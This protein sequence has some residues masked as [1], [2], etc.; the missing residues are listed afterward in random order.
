MKQK[1][2]ENEKEL[3]EKFWNLVGKRG[4]PSSPKNMVYGSEAYR[5]YTDIGFIWSVAK[6]LE[7]GIH[8]GW[9]TGM[10]YS[11]RISK[12]PDVSLI[13]RYVLGGWDGVKKVILSE[14]KRVFEQDVSSMDME[15]ERLERLN[16]WLDSGGLLTEESFTGCVATAREV[17]RRLEKKWKM[18]EEILNFLQI[19]EENI[20]QLRKEFQWRRDVLMR[21]KEEMLREARRVAQKAGLNLRKF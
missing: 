10:G 4:Y 16:R 18:Y 3:D 12:Y 13:F 21:K 14:I 8:V 6:D 7:K 1:T 17:G 2:L 9:S 15:M 11:H 19:S 5:V 20:S